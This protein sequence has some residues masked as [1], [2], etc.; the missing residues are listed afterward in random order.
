MICHVER[1]ETSLVF[2]RARLQEQIQRSFVVFATHD[3]NLK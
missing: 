1:S 3:G 2:P